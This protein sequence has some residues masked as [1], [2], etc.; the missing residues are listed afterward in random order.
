MTA[1]G[2]AKKLETAIKCSL[3]QEVKIQTI[4]EKYHL[5]I[6]DMEETTQEE[7]IIDG[8]LRVSG[9][10][11][12]SNI[13]VQNI[14]E[15]YGGTKQALVIVPENIAVKILKENKIKIG[16]VVCRVK[17]KTF[18]KRCFRCM[19]L[20]HFARDCRGKDRSQTC[21]RCGINGHKAKECKSEPRCI[22]CLEA[23][24]QKI[25]H[26]IGTDSQCR[27]GNNHGS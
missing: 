9:E 21:R 20:G 27:R 26:Y 10:E 23:G 24:N 18:E 17:R 13:K 25:N 6:R 5:D 14:R 22:I 19:E 1:D 8:I 2:Q 15:Y 7:E 11:D 3:R 16:L 12:A 4:V